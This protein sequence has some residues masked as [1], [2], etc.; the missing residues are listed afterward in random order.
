[1]AY[2]P[3]SPTE[4]ELL[5]ALLDHE[6]EGVHALRSQL[7]VAQVASS[8]ACGCGSIGFSFRGVDV[9]RS[10]ATG[11][12]PVEVEIVN[13]DGTVH[14]GVIVFVHDGLLGDV[15]VHSFGEG[16]LPMPALDHV[17]WVI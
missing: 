12:L 7:D 17:R 1:M 4:R 5:V 10:T 6:F 11:R 13:S 3:M 14:G 2:R 15:D 16:P 9:D 8:C